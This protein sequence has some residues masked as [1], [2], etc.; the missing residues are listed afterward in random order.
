MFQES[1]ESL[2]S[3]SLSYHPLFAFVLVS[4]NNIQLT[5][6]C[7]SHVDNFRPI[8][9][10]FKE[11]WIESNRKKKEKKRTTDKENLL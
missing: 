5:S 3:K 7:V 6:S 1:S 2:K 10:S 9:S 11:F 8:G 4:I